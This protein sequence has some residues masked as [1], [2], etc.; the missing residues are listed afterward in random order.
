M[1]EQEHNPEP[2]DSSLESCETITTDALVHRFAN[3]LGLVPS[4]LRCARIHLDD[5]ELLISELDRIEAQVKASL[6]LS[7]RFISNGIIK[8]GIRIVPV[9]VNSTIQTVLDEYSNPFETDKESPLFRLHLRPNLPTA[10]ADERWLAEVIHNL[11]H[12][13]VRTVSARRNG[14]IDIATHY[15]AGEIMINVADNGNGIPP[16][17]IPRLFRQGIVGDSRGLGFGLFISQKLMASWEGTLALAKSD[18]DGTTIRATLKAWEGKP[19]PLLGRRALIV[20]SYEVWRETVCDILLRHGFAGDKTASLA[21]VK[22]LIGAQKYQLAIL[23]IR[24]SDEDPDNADGLE[25]A[26]L[27]RNYNPEALII[28]LTGQGTMEQMREAFL[29]LGVYDFLSKSNFTEEEFDRV[30]ANA[31]LLLKG[32]DSFGK[33]VQ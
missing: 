17:L 6:A 30:I 26:R 23:A 20:D 3:L 33:N 8:S 2:T 18:A 7:E 27:I 22:E 5:K 12:N 19:I 29:V 32:E 28:M 11:I 10:K 1:S 15:E 24:L 16:A 25:C 4:W 14:V 9:D 31:A 13:S 21:S